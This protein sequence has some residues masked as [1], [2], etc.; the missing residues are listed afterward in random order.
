MFY[1]ELKG[2]AL[3]AYNTMVTNLRSRARAELKLSDSGIVVRPLRPEDL[4]LSNG[5]WY[6]NMDASSGS[7]WNTSDIDAKTVADNRFIGI[8]GVF[9]NNG[10]DVCAVRIT[11]EGATAREWD[12]ID[13]HNKKHKCG[14]VDDPVTIDQNTTVTVS[15]YLGAA[16]TLNNT[17]GLIGAIA[18]KRGLLINP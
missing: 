1:P 18:E 7:V 11:R 2:N 15:L 9:D 14:Y 5:E 8:N 16:S 4:G 17:F 3:E 10:G 13:I 6:L 12:V